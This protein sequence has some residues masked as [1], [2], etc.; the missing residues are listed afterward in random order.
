MSTDLMSNSTDFDSLKSKYNGFLKPAISLSV[1]SRSHRDKFIITDL[2]VELTSE[3]SANIATVNI[4]GIYNDKE[5]KFKDN[6]FN[7]VF[8]IGKKIN[9]DIGYSKTTECVFS[10]FISGLTYVFDDRD[11]PHISLEC[12]DVKAAMMA[13]NNNTQIIQDSYSA[14]I[15]DI[16]GKSQ[17]KAYYKS[18]DIDSNIKSPDGEDK[19]LIEMTDESDYDFIVRVAKKLGYEFFVSQETLYFRKK[20]IKKDPLITMSHKDL[21]V[22][23]EA[24]YNVMGMVNSVEVRSLNDKTGQLIRAIAKSNAVYSNSSDAARVTQK[25]SKII[26]DPTITSD[27]QAQ[28]RANVELDNLLWKFG[29]FKIKTIGVPELIPGRFIRIKDLSENINKKVYVT[30]VMHSISSQGF[31]TYIE[32]RL[33]SL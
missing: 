26:I 7:S 2:N 19:P 8:Q 29:I 24:N 33:D 17:Y 1:I 23:L 25:A 9:I 10:G 30:K 28:D 13:N 15:S 12:L 6:D 3:F 14:C 16:V 4:F 20:R 31:K 27:S 11:I 22:N 32:A 21:I 5:K 18:S